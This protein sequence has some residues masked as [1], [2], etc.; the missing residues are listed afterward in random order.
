MAGLESLRS[1]LEDDPAAASTQAGLDVEPLRPLWDARR[2]SE[3]G[4]PEV[5]LYRD[6]VASKLALRDAFRAGSAPRHPGLRRWRDRQIAR[7][8]WELSRD[9]AEAI[10]HAPVAV[11]LC[12]GCSVG[13]WF[14]GV[15]A[16]KFREAWPYAPNVGLWNGVLGG[17]LDS[18]G[19]GAAHGFC[20]WATDPLDNPDYERFCLDFCRVLGRFPQTTT[21]L[22]LKDPERTRALLRV[23]QE[24]GCPINRFS[25]LSRGQLERVFATF[26]PEELVQVELVLQNPQS[27]VVKAYAGR[28]RETDR[29]KPDDPAESS[30]I[31]CVSG[32]LVNMV[33]RTVRLISPCSAGPHWPLG[34]RVHAQGRFEDAAGFASLLS[35]MATPHILRLDLPLEEPVG[36][37]PGIRLEL[38]GAGGFRLKSPFQEAHFPAAGQPGL[39][40]LGQALCEGTST[41]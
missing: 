36:W 35:S 2:R 14:C 33:E 34:Y 5:R 39:E 11:E 20:Y 38:D 16:A 7:C 27:Q 37:R 13:C 3:P 29:V 19:E 4:T 12:A 23:S 10:I 21:A 9:A 15:G 31:A 1:L 18:L 41:P 32:F 30:T 25:V 6:W 40:A 17:L 24:H 8:S 26:T 22:A 28:A